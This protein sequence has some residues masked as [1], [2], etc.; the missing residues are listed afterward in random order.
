M[1]R[2]LLLIGILGVVMGIATWW[3]GW[4]TVPLVGAAWGVA[5]RGEDYPA[6]TAGVAASLAWCVLLA[7]RAAQGPIGELSRRLGGVLGTP[8]WVP[9]L[10]AV[11]FPA[12]L[13]AAAAGFTGALTPAV[14]KRDRPA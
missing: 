8:G 12:I 3:I 10:A 7:V 6:A 5:R 2:H 11:A 1:R 14:G 13:A 9:L 4:W